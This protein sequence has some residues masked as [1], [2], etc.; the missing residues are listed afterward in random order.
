MLQGRLHLCPHVCSIVLFNFTERSSILK[1]KLTIQLENQIIPSKMWLVILG[2]D[3]TVNV[4]FN[5]F[6]N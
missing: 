5:R 6:N 2:S 4:A 3:R 1:Y